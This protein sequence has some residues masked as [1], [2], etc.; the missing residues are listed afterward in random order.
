MIDS[1]QGLPQ[2]PARTI[3]SGHKSVVNCLTANTHALREV[4]D[5][6]EA[7]FTNQTEESAFLAGYGISI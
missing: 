2:D 7:V 4:M 1:Q 5:T 3:A 6:L